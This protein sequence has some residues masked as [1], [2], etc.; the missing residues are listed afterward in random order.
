M[1]TLEF[2][3]PPE[4]G[5]I[6]LKS[7]LRGYCG[8]SARLMIRLKREPNG[9][10]VNG[11][12]AIVTRVLCAGDTVRLNLPDDEKQPE[13]APYPLSVVLEDDDLLVVEKPAGMPMYPS[14]GH[15]RDSLANAAAALFLERGRKIAFRPVYRLDRD[16]TGL[17]VLAKNA[18]CAARLAGKIQKEYFAVCEG[19]LSGTG[20][21]NAPIGLKSGHRVQREVTP[22]G[23]RAVTHWRALCSGG[24]H[25]LVGVCLETGRTHQIR[26]HFAHMGHP[27]A[28]DDLYGGSLEQIERQA[29]HC[30]NV[31]FAHPVTGAA[32]ALQSSFPRDMERLLRACGMENT[33]KQPGGPAEMSLHA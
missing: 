28:G 26:V 14:P 30:G 11:A 2:P 4:Y 8:V 19:I 29:L 21:M 22:N 33:Q 32:V 23:E 16:T 13:P 31:R 10:T 15:D 24:G 17:V 18:Y 1:R 12:Q 25:T 20:V 5:G 7:F 27:L 3:V 6:R 9:I